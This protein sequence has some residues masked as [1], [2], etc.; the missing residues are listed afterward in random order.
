MLDITKLECQI[1]KILVRLNYFFGFLLKKYLSKFLK[2]ISLEII[3]FIFLVFWVLFGQNIA[4]SFLIGALI[5]V[6]G[7]LYSSVI[8]LGSKAIS[9]KGEVSKFYLA[10]FGKWG[11]V[12]TLFVLTFVF[13]DIQNPLVFFLAFAFAALLTM[14]T[15]KKFL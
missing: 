14:I 15:N 6:L 5:H 13:L 10:E 12:V 1:L 11:V 4:S 7:M 8:M 3:F 9:V 2:V